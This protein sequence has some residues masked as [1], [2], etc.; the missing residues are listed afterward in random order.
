MKLS[1]LNIIGTVAIIC[2]IKENNSIAG[3]YFMKLGIIEGR[4]I[5]LLKQGLFNKNALFSINNRLINVPKKF[6]ELLIVKKID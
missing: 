5:K 3:Q 6:Q 4:K 1:N 2:K